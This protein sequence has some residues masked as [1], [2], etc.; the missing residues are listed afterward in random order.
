MWIEEV[1][2]LKWEMGLA[3]GGIRRQLKKI[4][5]RQL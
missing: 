3:F 2:Y 5:G 1:V 4:N